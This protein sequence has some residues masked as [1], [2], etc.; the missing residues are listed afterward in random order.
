MN[1]NK[2][3]LVVDDDLETRMIASGY[4]AQLDID[5]TVVDSVGECLAQLVQ[6]PDA[7]SM[8]LMD[9]HMPSLSGVDAMT[10]IRDSEIDPPRNMPIV[11]LTGD[12]R[13]HDQEYVEE[14]GMSGFIPKPVTLEN[15]QAIVQPLSTA[16]TAR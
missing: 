10:W 11:A 16:T 12:A 8:L 13:Y 3:V 14:I 4:L 9:I 7:F 15:L 5:H 1:N 2:K 6:D